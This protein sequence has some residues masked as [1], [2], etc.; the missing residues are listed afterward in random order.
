M[1]FVLYVLLCACIQLVFNCTNK[2]HFCKI[3]P[4][5]VMHQTKIYFD[6][7]IHLQHCI[8]Y[9]G[10]TFVSSMHFYATTYMVQILS[11]VPYEY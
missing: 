6:N 7:W 9:Q 5:C 3:K 8:E 10:F 1:F 4:L 11:V 2:N